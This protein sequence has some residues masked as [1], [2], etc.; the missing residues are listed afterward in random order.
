MRATTTATMMPAK[1]DLHTD[2]DTIRPVGGPDAPPRESPVAS[3]P[4]GSLARVT[5]LNRRYM[6]LPPELDSASTGL[7]PDWSDPATAA[8]SDRVLE[9]QVGG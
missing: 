2:L 6:E 5:R 9:K 1:L 7:Y 4:R 3:A 8:W